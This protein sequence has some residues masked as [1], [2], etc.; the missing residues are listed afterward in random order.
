MKIKTKAGDFVMGERNICKYCKYKT[1]GRYEGEIGCSLIDDY[2]DANNTCDDF[3]DIS[4]TPEF[5]GKLQ[6]IANFYSKY[7]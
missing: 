6:S 7:K 3:I 4:T 1:R 5:R 2:V